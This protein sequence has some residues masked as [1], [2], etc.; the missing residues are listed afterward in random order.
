MEGYRKEL[1]INSE[2][3]EKVLYKFGDT[4]MYF[5]EI[6]EGD[7]VHCNILF[8]KI[9]MYNESIMDG[10]VESNELINN[11]I[12]SFTFPELKYS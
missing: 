4:F 10:T 5:N 1:R 7:Y 12:I 6:I 2:T 9:G 3:E 8:Y 11:V